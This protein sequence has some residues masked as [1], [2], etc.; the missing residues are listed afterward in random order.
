VVATRKESQNNIPGQLIPTVKTPLV[1]VSEVIVN[2]VLQVTGI[3]VTGFNHE[4]TND[5]IRHIINNHSDAKSELSRGNLP[6][7]DVDFEKIPDIISRPTYTVF[8]A[9][10]DG[11]QKIV[12][13]KNEVDGSSFYFEE[14]LSGKKNKSLRSNTFYKTNRVLDQSQILKTIEKNHKTDISQAVI[15]GG[16]GG[17]HPT[18]SPLIGATVTNPVARPS[19]SVSSNSIEKSSVAD[20]FSRDDAGARADRDAVWTRALAILGARA[21]DRAF[22]SDFVSDV[23][24]I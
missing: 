21:G 15:V 10:R 17:G 5:F 22:V 16:S 8:G 11:S 20:I 14:I 9:K 19:N 2:N 13:V 7:K 4:I 23:F 1:K 3:D 18:Y 12:Y 6:I 24:Y